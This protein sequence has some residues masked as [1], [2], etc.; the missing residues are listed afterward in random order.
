MNEVVVRALTTALGD[1]PSL[2]TFFASYL[3]WLLFILYPFV[4]VWRPREKWREEI[5]FVLTVVLTAWVASLAIKYFYA[6]PR[7]FLE[8]D[9]YTPL[10]K[11]GG[12]D[13]FP[14][15]HATVFFAFGFA[16]YSYRH[17]FGNILI[18]GAALISLARIAAGLHWLSDV[19]GGFVLAGLVT[20]LLR[21]V[22]NHEGLHKT[23]VRL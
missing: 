14:S 2:V 15:G 13:S 5:I 8:L 10:M 17:L 20:I 18:L 19:I 9:N 7:P 6:S 11:Y 3:G 21:M 23:A 22:F 4:L 1:A 12:P 16:V